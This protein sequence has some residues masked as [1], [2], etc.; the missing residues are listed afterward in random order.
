MKLQQIEKITSY[1]KKE[2]ACITVGNL[3]KELLAMTLF[4]DKDDIMFDPLDYHYNPGD[5]INV[6]ESLNAVVHSKSIYE[7]NQKIA[8]T[9]SGA[10]N[11]EKGHT[12]TFT[13]F[14]TMPWESKKPP[15][16]ISDCKKKNGSCPLVMH[17][18]KS[19]DKM[20]DTLFELG[21][22]QQSRSGQQKYLGRGRGY[23][24]FESIIN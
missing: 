4:G 21:L 2:I 20:F 23:L 7:A 9:L 24:F 13:L 17:P 14:F 5:G 3:V 10:I 1:P 16:I 22:Y 11:N 18:K 19:Q 15:E 8:L 12:N 6:T